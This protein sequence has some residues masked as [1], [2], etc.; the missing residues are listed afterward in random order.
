[1]IQDL[2]QYVWQTLGTFGDNSRADNRVYPIYMIWHQAVGRRPRGGSHAITTVP[3]SPRSPAPAAACSTPSAPA[4]IYGHG[5]RLGPTSSP[6]F[7][8]KFQYTTSNRDA[9][10]WPAAVVIG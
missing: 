1:M 10:G 4:P 6:P 9:R 2:K 8:L 7:L 5:R 3:Q